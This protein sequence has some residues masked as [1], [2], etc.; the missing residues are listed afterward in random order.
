MK[1]FSALGEIFIFTADSA[2]LALPLNLQEKPVNISIIKKSILPFLLLLVDDCIFL[3]IL[4]MAVHNEQLLRISK[5]N[6]R[7]Q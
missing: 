6:V 3:V 7:Y 4:A 5:G 1:S 2:P